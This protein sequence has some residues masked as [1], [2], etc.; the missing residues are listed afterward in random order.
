[1]FVAEAYTGRA[2]RYVPREET[3]RGFKEILEGKHDS[4]PEQAFFMQ[5]TID[6]CRRR[7]S[8]N[9]GNGIMSIRVDIVTAERLVF[10]QDADIV[11]VPGVEGEMGILPHHETHHDDDQTG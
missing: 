1:M 5:G 10:S 6:G 4:L 7:G 8:E 11:M 2:G 9:G 3:V